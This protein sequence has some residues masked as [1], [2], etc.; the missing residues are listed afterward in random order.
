MKNIETIL[1]D[2]NVTLTDEQKTAIM[3][4]VEENYKPIADYDKQKDKLDTAN[5]QIVELTKNLE[6]LQGIDPEEIKTLKATIEAKDKELA[7]KL[8]E[9]D[10]NDSVKEAIRT[11]KGRNEKAITA[12]LDI[13][14]LK[15]SKN[16][17]EDIAAALK[18]LSEAE[19]SKFLFGEAEVVGNESFIGQVT[20]NSGG[21]DDSQFRE[22]MGLPP[23]KRD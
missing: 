3:A 7:D 4:A 16:Q 17:K 6:K 1:S 13:E 5:E 23:I 12:L 21:S 10:F 9:R 2:N 20:R 11:A 22:I 19:D 8:A 14:A 15:K 18:T